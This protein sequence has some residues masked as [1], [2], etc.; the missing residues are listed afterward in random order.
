[1]RVRVR[2]RVRRWLFLLL[3]SIPSTAAALSGG[4]ADWSWRSSAEAGG[5][6]VSWAD[7]ADYT[8]AT[9]LGLG[10][11]DSA[12][13]KLPFSFPFYG[14]D[15][16]EITVY[17]YGVVVPGSPTDD[18]GER[19]SGSCIS[20][21]DYDGPLIAPLWTTY[22]LDV[23]GGV[24]V[25]TYDDAV[26]IEWASVFVESDDT[27]SHSVGVTLF[28]TGEIGLIYQKT[29]TGDSGTRSGQSATSGIQSGDGDVVELGCETSYVSSNL[30]SIYLTP[31]GLRHFVGE[32]TVT[33]IDDAS[34][35]GAAASDRLGYSVAALE[36]ID[37]DGF[38]DLLVGAPL[39]DD[40]GSNAGVAY[41]ISGAD[42]DGALS[43][44]AAS[45]TVTGDKS[46]QLGFSVSSA[47]DVDGD[48]IPD[49]LIGAPYND[50]GAINGGAAA[51]LLGSSFSGAFDLSDTD[52]VFSGASSNDYAG[53][54]VSSA[55]DVDGDGYGDLLIGAPYSDDGAT[56]GGTAYLVLGASSVS[57][58]SLSSADASF[59]G[60]S[61]SDYAGAA[62]SALG[63]LDG[64][65]FDDFGIGAY[66]ED[67]AG[68]GAGAIGIVLGSASL[69]GASALSDLDMV[70]GADS[71]DAAG[72]SF[73]ALG[74]TD[75]DGFD[76]FVVGAY[77]A[78]TN[79]SGA[80]SLLAGSE[81]G[82]VSDLGSSDGEVLGQSADRLGRSLSGLDL[83]GSDNLGVVAG[84][85]GN[86]DGAS[87][88]G[89]VVIAAVADFSGTSQDAGEAHGLLLGSDSNGYLGFSVT[90]GDFN[91]DGY[92]DIAAGA[93]G[94]DGD[95]SAS[96]VAYV[97][98]G[99]PAYP[100]A[101]GDGHLSSD[102]G[103]L[104]CDDT[105]ATIGP[106]VSE[107]CDGIDNDCDGTADEGYGDGDSDGIPDCLDT[108]EC[109]GLDNDGDGDVDEGMAD[110]DGD[111]TCD[112]LDTEDCDGLDNDGDGSI[113]EGFRDG[114]SDG[115][116][117]CVD[118]EECDGIDND[119]D[120]TID[121][122]Y[123][124]TDGD[125]TADCVDG[126]GCDGLDN[127][128]DGLIDED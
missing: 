90:S 97:V 114:D 52:A 9:D 110:T 94:A 40:G 123:K 3:C 99:R 46:D 60:E 26:I 17:A 101:D 79:N 117:D 16:S 126:E 107:S 13:I 15:Y 70:T 69:S 47:G 24:Y 72:I 106:G 98:F 12:T 32:Q 35:L 87:A 124:D 42:L 63:D 33:D 39:S 102:Q 22:D 45:A 2:V 120:G 104:D 49:A 5:P 100:D 8:D 6:P 80:F 66:G 36:D 92:D 4:D 88:A 108:E 20:D 96:G 31:W 10:T 113:D 118:V 109:D 41:L 1:M 65:G 125:G 56:N 84:A 128:G 91:G 119:G 112:A 50:S 29:S 28:A 115:I 34:L 82:W 89:A 54:A 19:G 59:Y 71:G 83:G 68:A 67:T 48:G 74:D 21:G 55:G 23:G 58:S 76:D 61:S 57:D 64:D 116:A 85:Y 25:A 93:Y 95:S 38:D 105:D 77:T 73:T 62:V 18:P 43:T 75:G 81:S 127:D 27:G 103:G 11:G 86:S 121:E 122:D 37:E 51:L 30:D 7:L 44:T 14:T 78:G 111:G 53:W